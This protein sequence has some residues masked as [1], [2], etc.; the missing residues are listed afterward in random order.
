MNT[1]TMFV[2][3]KSFISA[4]Y[5][6]GRAELLDR[7]EFEVYVDANNLRQVSYS[8]DEI[9]SC[10]DDSYEQTFDQYYRTERILRHMADFIKS[11]Y[12]RKKK[13]TEWKTSHLSQ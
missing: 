3:T 7:N 13:V 4:Y 1:I 2:K 11:K 8:G 6:D 10:G 9:E 5:E 12:E